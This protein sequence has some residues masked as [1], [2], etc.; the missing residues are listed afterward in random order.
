MQ[1]SQNVGVLIA[2]GV[3]SPLSS[4]NLPNPYLRG[5][6]TRISNLKLLVSY[7]SPSFHCRYSCIAHRGFIPDC[8]FSLSRHMV[9][10]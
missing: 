9:L 2:C 1:S 7:V 5:Q 4:P 10:L 6:K 8:S 3:V